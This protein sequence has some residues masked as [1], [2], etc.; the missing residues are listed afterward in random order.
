MVTIAFIETFTIDEQRD[1]VFIKLDEMH[2]FKAHYASE[3]NKFSFCKKGKDV[4]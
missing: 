3:I 1:F 4:F 2:L